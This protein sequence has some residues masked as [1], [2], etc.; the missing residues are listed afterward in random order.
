MREGGVKHGLGQPTREASWLTLF[1][2]TRIGQ[3]MM[4][5]F[6][7][8]DQTNH[9]VQGGVLFGGTM[10]AFIHQLLDFS[11]HAPVFGGGSDDSRKD[12]RHYSSRCT[13]SGENAGRQT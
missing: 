5:L 6:V 8:L 1:V 10:F 2:K 12:L 9:Q 13:V 3:R 11:Q 4:F 7:V